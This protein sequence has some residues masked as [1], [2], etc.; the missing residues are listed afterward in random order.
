MTERNY[1][2]QAKLNTTHHIND[3]TAK[4]KALMS[5]N[6]GITR[7]ADLL[8]Q[9]LVKIQGWQQAIQLS[10]LDDL[11]GLSNLDIIDNATTPKHLLQFRLERQLQ[12]ATLI[13]Q[14]AYQRCESRG[15]HYRK[16]YPAYACQPL[17]SVIEPVTDKA[18]NLTATSE[19]LS[20]SLSV[21]NCA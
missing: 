7:S 2:N 16:D 14:S 17:I 18:N 5:Q 20:I 13:V 10:G 19:W 15:G 12:L 3:I 9:A 8:A 1:N 21:M 6:M 4:L 11:T